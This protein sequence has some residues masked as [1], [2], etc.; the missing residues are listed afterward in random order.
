[1]VPSAAG[2]AAFAERRLPLEERIEAMTARRPRGV[3]WRWSARGAVAGT[4]V[5]AAC[6]APRPSATSPDS[7]A[8]RIVGESAGMK[9]GG[10]GGALALPGGAVVD[11]PPSSRWRLTRAE[12]TSGDGVT[13]LPIDRENSFAALRT[14]F[15]RAGV[16]PLTDRTIA[17]VVLDPSNRIIAES[18]QEV[19]RMPASLEVRPVDMYRHFPSLPKSLEVMGT[20]I[21]DGRTLGAAP[22]AQVLYWTLGE[23]SANGPL[24]NDAQAH[25]AQDAESR[26]L[27][28]LMRTYFARHDIAKPA[29]KTIVFLAIDA[30]GRVIGDVREPR[31]DRPDGS[32]SV[33]VTPEVIRRVFP[34][35]P[36]DVPRH[37]GIS[38]AESIGLRGVDATIVYEYLQEKE[39]P[40]EVATRR[41]IAQLFAER[42]GPPRDTAVGVVAVFGAGW[43]LLDV[44]RVPV[45]DVPTF[46]GVRPSVR[47][48]LLPSLRGR[49]VGIEGV[50]TGEGRWGVA[51]GS[52]VHV[53]KLEDPR[54]QRHIDRAWIQD[55]VGE[56][57]GRHFS[58]T[59][60]PGGTVTAW[61]LLDPAGR[62]LEIVL[63][64][65][66]PGSVTLDT[67]RQRLPLAH[68]HQIEGFGHLDGEPYGL[69]ATSRIVWALVMKPEDVR[70]RGLPDSPE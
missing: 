31:G 70:R 57:L 46:T 23:P 43:R 29:A 5:L 49:E 19:S 12:P 15:S 50:T 60:R 32:H 56:A 26:L 14:H 25:A 65:A 28:Q 9:V 33:N 27:A 42:G 53:W 45:A 40:Q 48:R 10:R 41:A 55:R 3:A 36:S 35:L 44:R 51:D 21:V 16:T 1:V 34:A 52:V 62:A 17:Y 67:V 64:D 13:P 66:P 8:M 11:L 6:M 30:D 22:R 2:L 68:G 4:L 24:R 7:P 20:G 39:H 54:R 63:H 69:Q 58:R 37:S 59:S 61:V 47:E 18:R 38:D